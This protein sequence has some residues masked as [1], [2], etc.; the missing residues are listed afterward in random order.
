FT[1]RTSR[2]SAT[3]PRARASGAVRSDRTGYRTRN[4]ASTIPRGTGSIYRS[5]AGRHNRFHCA[6]PVSLDVLKKVRLRSP[7]R[8]APRLWIVFDR[9]DAFERIPVK[10][11]LGFLISL[12]FAAIFACDASAADKLVADFGGV[13]G[14]QS[15]SWVAKDLKLFDKYGLNVDLVMI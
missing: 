12:F 11:A 10:T 9:P 2:R 7:D 8:R 14:F 6:R 4:T 5:R 3:A 1:S 13:S 15:A